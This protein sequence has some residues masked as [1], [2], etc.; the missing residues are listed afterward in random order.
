MRFLAPLCLALV[1]ACPAPPS[2]QAPSASQRIDADPEYATS[3]VARIQAQREHAAFRRELAELRREVADLRERLG[4]R[5]STERVPRAR[6]NRP[7]P[8]DTYAVP[9]MGFPTEG[10]ADAL[11]TIVKAYEFACPFCDKVRTTLAQLK[12]DYDADLRIVYR[13]MIVHPKDA[14]PAALAVCA[15]QQQGRWKQLYELLWTGA[16]RKRDFTEAN[17]ESLA[18][19]AGLNMQAYRSAVNGV[20]PAT[21]KAD[22]AEL[23]KFGVRGT[24]AFFIN[25]RF[26]SGA[27]PI[28]RF[29]KL[30]DEELEIAKRKL[31][32]DRTLNP[33]N[34]YEREIIAKGKQSL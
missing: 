12:K 30:I 22:Q 29:K 27:Q 9:V 7:N 8:A 26:L 31:G 2:P 24:P 34:Y 14:T 20:C 17:I 13:T 3:E 4:N 28:D 11:V 1:A 32:R 6:F 16:F 21:V 19:K 5:P 33:F 23:A 15:A 18:R 25:G 10:Q